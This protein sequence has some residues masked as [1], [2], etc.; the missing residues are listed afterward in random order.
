[1]K[2]EMYISKFLS[3]IESGNLNSVTQ[4]LLQKPALIPTFVWTMNLSHIRGVS[5][6]PEAFEF[7]ESNSLIV[8]D[9]WPVIYLTKALESREVSRVPGV[10]LVDALLANGI[11]F[12]VIGSDQG[13]VIKTMKFRNYAESELTFVYDKYIDI[14]SEIQINEII[15]LLFEFKPHYIFLALGFP[16]QEILFERIRS[17]SPLIPAY[18]LGIGGSFQMLSREKVRA[19]RMFQDLGLEWLWRLTQDPKRLFKRYYLD[20]KFLMLIIIERNVQRAHDTIKK[21]T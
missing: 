15:Q 20:C 21:W 14:N 19:P 17:K 7:L 5:T 9:G 1:M 8:A 3:R 13:Q 11:K 6:D 16:K 18:F 4:Y 2:P 12:S 10:D